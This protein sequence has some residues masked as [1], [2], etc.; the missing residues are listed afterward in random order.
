MSFYGPLPLL[1]GLLATA[2]TWLSIRAEGYVYDTRLLPLDNL[3][4]FVVHILRL[5]STLARIDPTGPA[6]AEKVAAA[7]VK[8]DGMGLSQWRKAWQGA[9]THEELT[10]NEHVTLD[11]HRPQDS[12]SNKELPLIIWYHGGG[13]CIGSSK[14]GALRNVFETFEGRAVIASV[15]YRMAP[16]HPYPA[17]ADD[18]IAALEWLSARAAE[19]GAG[20]GLCLAGLSAGG[21]LAAV[22]AHHAA[23]RGIALRYVALLIPELHI[24]CGNAMSGSPAQGLG[25]HAWRPHDCPHSVPNHRRARV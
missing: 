2:T 1:L 5:I 12:G 22:A 23:E 7:R 14:D 17:A 24:N 15:S 25:H 6:A 9:W 18:A 20:G 13:H 11:L 3:I 10:V 21:N 8:M 4:C 19:L 16:E